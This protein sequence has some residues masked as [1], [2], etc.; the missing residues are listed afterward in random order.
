MFVKKSRLNALTMTTLIPLLSLLVITGCVSCAKST[1]SDP[2]SGQE[3]PSSSTAQSSA[4]LIAA[5]KTVFD[6]NG[7][8][9]CHALNGQ[10]GRQGPELTHVGAESEHTSDW[11]VAHVKNPRMHN[12]RSR[13]PSFEGKINDKD[14]LAL[15]AYLSS[16]K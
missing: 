10:G 8:A 2:G 14:L 13:M 1:E 15:G 12:P 9:R 5:G 16:L 11:I 6:A 3:N 4:T 7:C